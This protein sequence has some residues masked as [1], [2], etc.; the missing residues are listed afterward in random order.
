MAGYVGKDLYL[1]FDGTVLDT[2]FRSFNPSE[3]IGLVDQSA[4]ADTGSTWLTTLITGTAAAAFVLQAADTATWGVLTPGS[5]GTLEWGEE[6][7]ASGKPRHYINAIV[8]S[9]EK[10]IDYG[11]VVICNSTFRYSA[12]TGVT[13]TTY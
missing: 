9:R 12:Q 11:D 2:D 7:T 5:E 4:G 1:S 3:E 13:D 8:V 10:T 6:G